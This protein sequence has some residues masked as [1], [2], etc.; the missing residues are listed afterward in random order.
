MPHTLH[1]TIAQVTQTIIER[2]RQTR[3]DY[4]AKIRLQ[5]QAPKVAR[6]ELGCANLAHVQAASTA[7]EK[8]ILLHQQ[9][10]NIGIITAYNDVL[11]AHQPYEHYPALIKAA[12]QKKGAVA[13]VTGAVPAM[14]DG[15][16]QGRAG[17]ELSLFSRDVIAMSTAVGASHDVFDGMMYLGVCDKIVPGLL[18]G[19][20][21]YGHLPAI[22]V[23]AGPMTSGLSNKEKA[24]VREEF[25]AGRVTKTDLLAAE[26]ASYHGAGTC[27]FYGTANSN[28]LLMDVMGLHLSG[29]A[30]VPHGPLRQALTERATEV[31]ID[32][33]DARLQQG[34]KFTHALGLIVDEK[35]IVNAII[36]LL[37]T[38]GST[39]HTL[40]W[41]A[42]ARAAG[43][44]INWDDFSA[45][46]A[47]IPL[48]TKIYPNGTADVNQ[49]HQA[50]GTP[51]LIHALLDAGLLHADV[52]TVT[53]AQESGLYAQ[54][55]MPSLQNG[56]VAFSPCADKSAD[57]AVLRA[58]I[59]AFAPQGGL[60]VLKGN[61]GRGI[62]KVSA[63]AAQHQRV[64]APA[65]L[66]D[67]QEEMLARYAAG[68]LREHF[69]AVLR[70]Q[71]PRANGMP[72]LHKL[73]PLLGNLQ[74][75]GFSVA[76]VTDGRLSGA[77]GKV[78][79]AIHVCPETQDGGPIGKIMEGDVIVLDAT[80]G[81]L[82][83]QVDAAE[84]AQRKDARRAAVATTGY[85]R[86]LF[87]GFRQQVGTAEE[88]ASVLF[89]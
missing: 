38:G 50:G 5:N 23:P 49:F 4:L 29:A 9:Q 25:A 88:G 66:F 75:E 58:P 37:A 87:A 69:I 61:L 52:V 68:G 85:G 79:A 6:H 7:S 33:S 48:L 64:I 59:D 40:H 27:T 55:L 15:I 78:P 65:R 84:W 36:A 71:G 62:I 13:Q 63:V 60:V 1:P 81:E 39:N 35:C 24:K 42:V 74:N 20:L 3:Q 47:V 70:Y 73:M 83:V 41:V 11:S 86:E 45:L 22:F 80:T 17:M 10:V 16:T 67:S 43:I 82:S 2:S 30:F 34:A 32:W 51:W 18:L 76:L 19:A 26:T 14:C 77:S 57:D 28:Q 31:L 12:A 56:R 8:T 53:P 89:V 44:L 54:T 72:E 46:S 21:S